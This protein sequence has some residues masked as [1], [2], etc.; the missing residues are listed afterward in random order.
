MGWASLMLPLTQHSRKLIK[1]L[2]RPVPWVSHS[3][4]A[5]TDHGCP[6]HDPGLARL[7]TIAPLTDRGDCAV[8]WEQSSLTRNGRSSPLSST[9]LSLNS[10]DPPNRVFDSKG[11]KH[12]LSSLPPCME[13]NNHGQMGLVHCTERLPS[14]ICH[15]P[16]P[17]HFVITPSTPLF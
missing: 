1:I 15:P 17:S 13:G 10:P 7:S 11:G 9:R 12:L 8:L 5:S 2:K 16:P 4:P 6:T 3:R 14:R